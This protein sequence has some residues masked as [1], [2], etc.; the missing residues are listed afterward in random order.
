MFPY[1][2]N[3]IISIDFHIFQRGGPTTNQYGW[4]ESAMFGESVGNRWVCLKQCSINPGS[5]HHSPERKAPDKW[6]MQPWPRKAIHP[7]KDI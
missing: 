2:G 5:V 6:N 3:L 7:V 4:G 1:I